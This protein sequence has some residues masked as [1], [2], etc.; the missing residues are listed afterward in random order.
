[1][2]LYHKDRRILTE[3]SPVH[4]EQHLQYEEDQGC[5]QCAPATSQ[6]ENR[7]KD[8]C[9]KIEKTIFI[10]KASVDIVFRIQHK[11]TISGLWVDCLINSSHISSSFCI[12]ANSK[13]CKCEQQSSSF[14]TKKIL[15]QK[16]IHNHVVTHHKNMNI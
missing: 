1:M 11:H 10:M 15:K 16:T 9:D 6:P 12:L 2:Q 8:E 14:I 13:A 4:Q 7:K 3:V 5:Q